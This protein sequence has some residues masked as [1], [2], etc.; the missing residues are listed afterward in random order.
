MIR[1]NPEFGEHPGAELMRRRDRCRA[2]PL[3]GTSSTGEEL[4]PS[5]PLGE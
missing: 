5:L 4:V 1:Q 2:E 3:D